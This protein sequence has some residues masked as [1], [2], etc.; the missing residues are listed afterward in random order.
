MTKAYTYLVAGLPE[1]SL[2]FSSSDPTTGVKRF[3]CDKLIDTITENLDK[4]DVKYLKFLLLGLDNPMP[5]FFRRASKSKNRFI[6]E[7]FLMDTFLRNVQA[8]VV[9][10]KKGE[11][12]HAW[13]V[14]DNTTDFEPDS[15][16]E[17][18]RQILDI[19]EIKDILER[20]QQLDLFRWK[21]VD[22]I[23]LFNY[24]DTDT[25]LAFVVKAYLVS[26]WMMLDKERGSGMFKKLLKDCRGVSEYTRLPE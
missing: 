18:V 19:L 22:E 15:E 10:R 16:V 13:L 4:E 8:G 21:K 20:E 23:N 14:G 6:R 5:Y 7:Y 17:D 25:V 9:A 1:L 24:F 2:E 3:D 26:R 11:D 12:P